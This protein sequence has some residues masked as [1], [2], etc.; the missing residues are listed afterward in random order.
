[1][2]TVDGRQI[3][4]GY[5]ERAV[6]PDGTRLTVRPL[7]AADAPA[8]LEGFERLSPR[9]RYL[10]FHGQR[11]ELTPEE[12][13]WLTQVDGETHLALAA[14]VG[15]RLVAVG[16]FV[17]C[18][19]DSAEIAL[20]V[21]DLLQQRG[22]GTLL[23]SR[24]R[25]AALERGIADFTGHVLEQNEAMLELLH[26]LGARIGLPSLGTHEIQLPLTASDP[27]ARAA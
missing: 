8:L 11:T 10:R 9:S 26:K 20:V 25:S 4:F 27:T 18:G 24:L 15:P 19:A 2:G 1:M 17:R 14:F 16:R 22:I 21:E 6:L 5:L 23:L 12:V 13:R 3:G 7:T